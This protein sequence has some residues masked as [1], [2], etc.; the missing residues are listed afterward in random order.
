MEQACVLTTADNLFEAWARSKDRRE[1]IKLECSILKLRRI[2]KLAKRQGVFE[3][4][5][6]MAVREGREWRWIRNERALSWV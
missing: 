2:S 4:D 5:E 1:E 3:I 6:L